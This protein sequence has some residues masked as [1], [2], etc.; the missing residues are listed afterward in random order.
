MTM[1]KSSRPKYYWGAVVAIIGLFILSGWVIKGKPKPK[2]IP[3]DIP[4]VK[5][6]IMSLNDSSAQSYS[7]SGEVR[8][9]YESRLAFQ[10]NG[11]II[12]RNVDLGSYVKKGEALFQIDPIDIQQGATASKAQ[13]LAA[14]SQYQLAKDNLERFREVYNQ[15]LMSKAEFDRYQTMYDA[16][17]AQ[18]RQARAQYTVSANQLN[19]CNLCADH[20]GVVAGIYAETGQ[21]VGA[22]QP[23]VTLVRDGEKEVEINVPEN[24]LEEVRNA[25]QLTVK[26]WAL[27]D[28]YITGKIRE[29]APM[30]NPLSRTYTMRISLLNPAPKLKLGM[31][32]TVV[33]AAAGET[34][35]VYIPLAAIYQT[36]KTPGVWIVKDDRTIHLRPVKVGR[37]GDEQVQ[38]LEGL[39][40]GDVVVAAGV[41]RLREGQK[42]Q[43]E[44]E[45]NE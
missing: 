39:K 35:M 27:P 32:A 11:K 31:T 29:V 14:E 36:G 20:S 2:K 28:H 22:G 17:D 1:R 9:R 45:R 26:F 30:A 24:R 5:T 3:K 16:A 33:T 15:K 42:V 19:Y 21:V 13:V 23:V 34:G 6:Q 7:Y 12:R 10:V 43:L 8:G 25:K 4:V 37:F 41:H 40:G 38:V 44:E 18:L